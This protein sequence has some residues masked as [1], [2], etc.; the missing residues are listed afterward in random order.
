MG[1]SLFVLY[2]RC[3]RTDLVKKP[4]LYIY[5]LI[6]DKIKKCSCMYHCICLKCLTNITDINS[7]NT[8]NIWPC[9]NIASY[10]RENSRIL[11]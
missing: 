3:A 10:I 5:I 2:P 8:K 6:T 7:F 11:I 1:N 9:V 4:M